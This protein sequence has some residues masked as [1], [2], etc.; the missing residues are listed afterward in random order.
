MTI[1]LVMWY[2]IFGLNMPVGT[3]FTTDKLRTTNESTNTKERANLEKGISDEK[4]WL[5]GTIY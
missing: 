3:T 4:K 1:G 5:K 2:L